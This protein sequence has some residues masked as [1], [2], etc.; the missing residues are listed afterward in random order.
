MKRLNET[1]GQPFKRG[2]VREDGFV[3]FN[4]TNKLKSTGFFMERWLSPECSIKVKAKDRAIKKAKYQRKTDRH[5]PGFDK[6]SPKVQATINQLK[7]VHGEQVQYQDL[8]F[9]NMVELLIGYELSPEELDL[10]I[11]HAQPLCFDA[12][13]VFQKVLSI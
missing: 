13:E 12:K 10:A 2:D 4:Y 9:D 8:S 6:L 11:M 7:Y 1:T 3:F 5:A